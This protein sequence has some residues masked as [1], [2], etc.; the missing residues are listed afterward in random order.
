M[1]R[2][3][4]KSRACFKACLPE[5]QGWQ[6]RNSFPFDHGW[7]RR[8]IPAPLEPIP[9]DVTRCLENHSIPCFLYSAV[10][11]VL[12]RG[13]GIPST[14]IRGEVDATAPAAL[15]RSGMLRVPGFGVPAD[16]VPGETGFD[17]EAHGRRRKDRLFEQ[18]VSPDRDF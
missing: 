1:K 10:A 15:K 2:P 13:R 4:H 17:R 18:S 14:S 9:A 16:L 12:W 6:N 7:R 5:R 3:A 11:A 8:K